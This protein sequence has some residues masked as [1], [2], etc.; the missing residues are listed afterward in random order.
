MDIYEFRKVL[1]EKSIEKIKAFVMTEL[2][3]A[4]EES[5]KFLEQ[6]GIVVNT[7]DGESYIDDG[8]ANPDD[9]IIDDEVEI[10]VPDPEPEVEIEPPKKEITEKELMELSAAGKTCEE[11]AAITGIPRS[12]VW[13]KLDKLKKEGASSKRKKK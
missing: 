10:P 3:I 13:Y 8:N 2:D 7:D 5:M 11:I 12:T 4:Q 6:I 9:Y 1:S